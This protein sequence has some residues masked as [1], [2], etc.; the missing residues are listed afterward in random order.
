LLTG[1]L[2]KIDDFDFQFQ[3]MSS[4]V[5]KHGVINNRSLFQVFI[6][7]LSYPAQ[8]ENHKAEI[9]GMSSPKEIKKE[10]AIFM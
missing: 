10:F 5:E 6:D 1:F 8:I 4:I 3:Q 9:Y 7:N 2:S